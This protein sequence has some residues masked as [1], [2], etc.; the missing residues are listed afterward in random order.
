MRLDARAKDRRIEQMIEDIE[1][2]QRNDREAR[3]IMGNREDSD[4]F[5]SHEIS[6]LSSQLSTL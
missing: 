2:M 3:E 6:L 4:K 1:R 5:D